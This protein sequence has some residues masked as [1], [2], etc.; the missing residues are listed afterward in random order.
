MKFPRLEGLDLTK[1]SSSVSSDQNTNT[2][3]SKEIVMLAGLGLLGVI[4]GVLLAGVA[5][6]WQGFVIV[7][8][9][10]W[11]ITPTFALAPLSLAVAVGIMFTARFIVGLWALNQPKEEDKKKAVWKPIATSFLVP[12]IYLLFGWLVTLF[13]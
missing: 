13:Q 2:Q 12:A 8:L 1:P 9:W 10:N 4:I 5:I 3:N 7:Q 6:V 11:F